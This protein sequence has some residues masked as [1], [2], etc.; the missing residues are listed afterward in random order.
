MELQL[1]KSISRFPFIHKGV[2]YDSIELQQNKTCI[3]KCKEKDCLDYFTNGNKQK[4]FI[5]K[6]GFDNFL[7][8]FDDLNYIVNGLI[9]K[10][11]K[12]IPKGRKDAR[13]DWIIEQNSLLLFEKKLIE[14]N[15]Y[16]KIRENE[17]IEK[18]FAMFHDFKTSMNILFT[19]TQDI[20]DNL[21]GGSFEEKLENSG[22]SYKDLFNALELIATQL[23]LID[24]IIN[25][26]SISFGTKREI[27]I[28]KL[29]YK[30]KLLFDHLA[31]KKRDV[32]IELVNID[33]AYIRNSNCY[34]SIE[35]I[36]LIL[37]DNA[38]KYSAPSSVVRIEI[39]QHYNK[40][41]VKVKSI[42]PLVCEN[43]KDKIFEKYF[44]D[45][46]AEEF[47]KTGIGMGLWIAQQIL[48]TH[49]S[50]ISYSKDKYAPGKIG[51]N[52]FEF[53]LETL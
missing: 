6:K 4:H 10:S 31:V 35:F 20:I 1:F 17:S 8:S 43:N 9:T 42:G 7:I 52:I 23:G 41:R 18:N 28:Y 13:L 24:V 15:K 46:S 3:Q 39:S 51:L 12:V 32:T 22:K 25:P 14:I 50:K 44:R 16:I 38:L 48:N 5:C 45:K 49:D 30:I 36:P 21:A 27:N 34:E 40:A 37:L 29:F 53:D 47:S 2:F 26:Q 33:G 11:N 19:C